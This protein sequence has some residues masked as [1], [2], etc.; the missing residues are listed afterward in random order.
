MFFQIH[1]HCIN[2]SIIQ[3]TLNIIKIADCETEKKQYKEDIKDIKNR[4]GI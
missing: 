2:D 4:E 1:R 3:T